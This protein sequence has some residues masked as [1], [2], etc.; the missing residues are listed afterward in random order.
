MKQAGLIHSKKDHSH[1]NR[2]ERKLTIVL[3]IVLH[4]VIFSCSEGDN[5]SKYDPPSDHTVSMDG[6]LHKSGLNQPTINCVACHGDNLEG[7]TS[8]VSC[9]ECHG[10]KW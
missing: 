10:K 2:T 3:W 8:Q 5:Y 7:G 4:L 9:Y 1:K 6:A